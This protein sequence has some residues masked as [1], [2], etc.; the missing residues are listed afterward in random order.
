MT[1]I[2]TLIALLVERFF[3]WG[4]MRRWGW[5]NQYLQW[6]NGKN[7]RFACVLIL[8]AG[9]LPPVL[10]V[11]V[12][13]WLLSGFWYDFLYLIFSLAI[14]IYCM[15]PENLW[16]QVYLCVNGLNR[17]DLSVALGQAEKSFH[18]S[19]ADGPQQFH[20][21]F[22][23]A[24][25][26][27]ANQ[28]I[29]AVIF[30]FV[31]LGPVGAVLYRLIELCYVQGIFLSC[32][33]S[34]WQA[35]RILDWIPVRIFAFLFALVGH[36]QQVF[37]QWKANLLRGVQYNDELIGECGVAA[38]DVVQNSQLPED[39]TAEKEALALLDRTFILGLVIIAAVVLI[40]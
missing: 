18:I 32:T 8:V 25:Y 31:V 23:R 2:A 27:A 33:N 26:V 29:F 39:G 15:G 9:V 12:L 36:F 37:T 13:S 21:L 30:W 11:G 1:F 34:A 28:R 4:H 6:L 7:T 17:N 19:P 5:F 3:D 14:L 24:I 22:T 40:F 16:S 35:K 10:I 38:L 20:Q